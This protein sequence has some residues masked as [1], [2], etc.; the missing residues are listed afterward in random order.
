MSETEVALQW[1]LC[2][3]AAVTTHAPLP[4][5]EV[6]LEAGTRISLDTDPSFEQGLLVDTRTLTTD[7]RPAGQDHLA[8]GPV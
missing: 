1:I 6:L 5:A 3:T 8:S 7:G 2:A 4:G